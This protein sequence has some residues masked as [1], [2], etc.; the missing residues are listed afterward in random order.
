[1]GELYEFNQR[2]ETSFLQWMET[3]TV[4]EHEKFLDFTRDLHVSLT[5]QFG[6]P[7]NTEKDVIA[8]EIVA[9]ILTANG[10]S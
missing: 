3:L 5:V 6:D 10:R 7:W 8:P 1:M 9:R 2:E 4:N